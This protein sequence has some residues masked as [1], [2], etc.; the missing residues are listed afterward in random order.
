MVVGT[1]GGGL[2]AKDYLGLFMADHKILE[3]DGGL[4]QVNAPWGADDLGKVVCMLGAE[5]SRR[6]RRGRGEAVDV[7]R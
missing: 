7:G 2:H 5:R 6:S 1:K 3:G 4:Y